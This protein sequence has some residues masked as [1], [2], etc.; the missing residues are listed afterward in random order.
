MHS[1]THSPVLSLLLAFALYLLS[2]FAVIL[3]N[4]HEAE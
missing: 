3:S 4:A 2:L 1:N